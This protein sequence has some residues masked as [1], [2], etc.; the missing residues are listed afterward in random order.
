MKRTQIEKMKNY[1]EKT[2]LTRREDR[3]YSLEFCEGDAILS[4]AKQDTFKAVLLAFEYG[5]A[6]GR[7]AAMAQARREG[8][9]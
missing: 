7:R 1:I 2:P 8:M 3:L 6:K 9:A 4:L 5:R